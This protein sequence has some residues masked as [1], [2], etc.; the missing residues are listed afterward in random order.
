VLYRSRKT[1]STSREVIW[2][3]MQK[4]WVSE[5][6]VQLI[7]RMYDE[8]QFCVKWSYEEVI[9]PLI[10]GLVSDKAVILLL[11]SLI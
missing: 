10:Q 1:E 8:I 9:E 5:N 4:K 3:K 7:Q 6:K 11:I 2:Y